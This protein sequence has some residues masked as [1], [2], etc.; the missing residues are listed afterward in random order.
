MEMW[1]ILGLKSDH[2]VE[3]WLHGL[4]GLGL[5]GFGRPVCEIIVI[6]SLSLPG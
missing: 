2:K 4:L 6:C 5:A 3:I 1:K